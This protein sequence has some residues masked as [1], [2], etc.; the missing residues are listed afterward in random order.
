MYQNELKR[1]SMSVICFLSIKN[2]GDQGW[3]S[4]TKK[5]S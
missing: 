3:R 4:D 1:K 5:L 2:Q